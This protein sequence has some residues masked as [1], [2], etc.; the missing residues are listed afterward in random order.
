MNELSLR[1]RDAIHR[2]SSRKKEK[3]VIDSENLET[4]RLKISNRYKNHVDRIIEQIPNKIERQF[5]LGEK[6]KF[7]YSSNDIYEILLEKVNIR[8]MQNH[9]CGWAN[10]YPGTYV[11]CLYNRLAELGLNPS[12]RYDQSF[13]AMFNGNGGWYGFMTI[14]VTNE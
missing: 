5:A 4:R 12:C 14:K 7:D 6:A 8:E 2:G 1:I 11:E 9:D 10:P 13:L 3:D